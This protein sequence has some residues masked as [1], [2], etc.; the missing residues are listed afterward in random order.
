MYGIGANTWIWVS[1]LTDERLAALAPRIAGWG[2]DT[3]ELPIESPG[4]WDPGRTADLLASLG[5]G[6]TTCAVMPPG[7][8][9]VTDDPDV[10]AGTADYLRACVRAAARIGARV[11]AGPIYAPV[12]RTW[13]LDPIGRR[14]TIRR[15][16]DRLRPLADEAAA[17]RVTLALEP[18]NRFETSLINTVE[19]GLEVVAAVDSPGLG[20][21]LDTFHMNIEERDLPAALRTAGRWLAHVQVCANDRG[22]PG[23]DHLDWPGIIDAL[24]EVGYS[25]PLCIESFTSENRTIATAA[26]IWRPLAPSQDE[27][28][29]AGLAFLRALL[30][31]RET[32]ARAGL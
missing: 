28:A 25:G 4:D 24:T 2:F 1:P 10:A 3:I 16:V 31:G 12:G 6:A 18:L 23:S 30:L 9:L 32:P 20:L 22:A 8:D 29:T 7:R 15:L 26:A 11:V 14:A 27:L 13:P 21:A 19:Q 17:H 5:L